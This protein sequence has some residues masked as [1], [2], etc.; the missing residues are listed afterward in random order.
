VHQT[1]QGT[2]NLWFPVQNHSDESL[3]AVSRWV[4]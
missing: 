4:L 2:V 3:S 1:C